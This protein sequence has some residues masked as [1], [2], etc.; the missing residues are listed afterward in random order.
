MLDHA[1]KILVRDPAVQRASLFASVIFNDLMHWE[2]NCC[3][4][5]FQALLG[6]MTK[7]M[8]LECD[9]NANQLPMFRNPDG[10][11][12][13]RINQVS[14]VTYL[15]TAR[16]I[17]LMF[18]WVHALGSQA[19][20][21]PRPCRTPALVVLA[22]MQIMILASQGRRAY[23]PQELNRVYVDTAQEF[24]SAIEFL[25]KYQQDHDTSVN[26]TTFSPMQ[27]GY[28]LHGDPETDSDGD[29]GASSKLWGSGHIEFSGK[30]IP[31]GSLH[32]PEQMMWG[33]HLY[34][35]DTCAPEA[36]HKMYIKKS[37]DRVRKCD[38]QTT[39]ESM[40]QWNLRI[41]TWSK[42]VRKVQCDYPSSIPRRAVTKAGVFTN[43]SK[44]LKPAASLR[45][46]FIGGSFS[47]L[48]AGGDNLMT[49]DARIS[50]H[51]VLNTYIWE[52]YMSGHI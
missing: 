8:Q 34:M 36:S 47:P 49:P 43:I 42:I 7:E 22:T 14:K 6:V 23:T 16:R 21:L 50:Y 2:L 51:E 9:N 46:L 25:M 39:A 40:I 29:G 13:R 37:M 45:R 5:A 41:R 10:S 20:M 48:R 38:D 15:T 52:S 30:G 1:D 18:V 12:I 11:A 28:S 3:D 33:G 32:F 24:F 44:R 4:Y 35:H 31:H 19:R 17:T 27:R 26:A